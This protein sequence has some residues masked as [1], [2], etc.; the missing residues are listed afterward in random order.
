M[1]HNCDLFCEAINVC[2][3]ITQGFF[4][5]HL[6]NKPLESK[7][8]NVSKLMTNAFCLAM[9]Y[10]ARPYQAR[11]MMSKWKPADLLPP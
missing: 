6:K 4:P 3:D 10:I 5:F 9:I 1:F 7:M 8:G 11:V 2:P